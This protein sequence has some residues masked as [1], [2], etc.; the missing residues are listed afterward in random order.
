MYLFWSFVFTKE[1]L[2]DELFFMFSN[3]CCYL[4]VHCA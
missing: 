2:G 1:T 3:V 4:A